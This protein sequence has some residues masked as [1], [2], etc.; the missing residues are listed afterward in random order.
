MFT[1]RIANDFFRSRCG[2]LNCHDFQIKV[3]LN[4]LIFYNYIL[5]TCE[6]FPVQN[7]RS[8]ACR[9]WLP[10]RPACSRSASVSA[11]SSRT[12]KLLCK[13]L[14]KPPWSNT[15]FLTRDGMKVFPLRKQ[16]CLLKKKISHFLGNEFK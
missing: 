15:K 16:N 5:K 13:R 3:L 8:S 1:K 9:D 2:L 4:Q 11:Q 14:P 7:P 12:S 10:I 6:L